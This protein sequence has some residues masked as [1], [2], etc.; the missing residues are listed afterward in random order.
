M[1]NQVKH[2]ILSP[3]A[4]IY[5]IVTGIRNWMFDQEILSTTEFSI[6]T[7][8]VGNLAVGGTGKTPHTEY[9]LSILQTEW[10]TAMLSRGYKRKTKG[11][12][13]SDEQSNSQTLGDEPYQIH[14]KFP[15]V[16]VAVD[17]KRVHGVKKLQELIPDLQLVVLDDA[18]QHRYIQAGL[19]ILLTDFNNLYS[20]D[21]L[22]PAGRLREWRSGSKRANI[23]VVTK[24]PEDMKPIDMRLYETELKPESNQLLFF[25]SFIYDELKP[26]FPRSEYEKWTFQ[27]IKEAN[28]EVLLVAGIVSPEPILD[29]LARYTNKVKT[30]FFEDH[31]DFQPKDFSLINKQ[32]DA[33]SSNEKI[34]LVTE[35]DAAR[36]VSNL[37]FPETL[38]TRTFALPIRVEI[39]HDQETLFIQKI[40][41]YV[42]E[43]SRNY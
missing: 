41:S 2:I 34:I 36:L 19:S 24:C 3:F 16:T 28:A 29:H 40:K 20:R 6:P 21:W 10:K 5:G 25:S 18:F 31:H 17:E 1:K 7:I 33:F 26:V 4:L 9:I 22:L 30:L 32:F 12:K 23:I 15:N 38:K 39:L 14:R 27:K 43:N 35:K 8:S 11:F 42:V 37:N 13:L